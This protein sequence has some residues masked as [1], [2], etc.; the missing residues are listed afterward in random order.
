MAATSFFARK[1][2]L[3]QDE[4]LHQPILQAV[5]FPQTPAYRFALRRAQ[6]LGLSVDDAKKL[7]SPP[8]HQ[9]D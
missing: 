7:L 8:K 2:G 9:D 1:D 5:D 3:K 4:M 6:R